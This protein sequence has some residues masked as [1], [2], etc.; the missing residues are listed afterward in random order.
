M[1][2]VDVCYPS[3]EA[4]ERDDLTAYA[5]HLL[6]TAREQLLSPLRAR[7]PCRTGGRHARLTTCGAGL[8][9][10]LDT[11]RG[12]LRSSAALRTGATTR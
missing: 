4:A 1:L 10:L 2:V 8:L 3:R 6:T 11:V 5:E 12:V 7:V 9:G